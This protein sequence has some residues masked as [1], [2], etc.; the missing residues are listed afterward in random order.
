MSLKISDR[1]KCIVINLLVLIKGHGNG[2]KYNL[3]IYTI[4]LVWV[5]DLNLR[6]KYPQVKLSYQ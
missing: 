3:Y 1:K 2:S 6:C 5:L 4:S